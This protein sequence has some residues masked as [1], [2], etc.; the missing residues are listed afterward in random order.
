MKLKELFEVEICKN[1]ISLS[2]AQ[3]NPGR[4]PYITT[5]AQNNGVECYVD[6]PAQYLS[7]IHI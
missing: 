3:E 2:Y 6:Y 5:T 4:T 1:H 7:L